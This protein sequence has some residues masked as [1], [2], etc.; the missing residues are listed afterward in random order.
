MMYNVEYSTK[1]KKQYRKMVKRGLNMAL[2]DEVVDMLVSGQT[3]PSKY[4]DHYLKGDWKG[5]KECHV[6]PDWL[7]IYKIENDTLLLTLQQT[8]THSD[9]F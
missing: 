8:G 5:F 4:R 6:A 1:Y 3:L 2:L 9:L 7:L